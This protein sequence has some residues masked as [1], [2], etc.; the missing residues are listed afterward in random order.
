MKLAL[1]LPRTKL[2]ALKAPKY[3]LT[4]EQRDKLI[5]ALEAVPINERFAVIVLW[6]QINGVQRYA[7][8]VQQVFSSAKWQATVSAAGLAFGHGISFLFSQ[9]AY[10][11]KAKR[12]AE[13]VKLMGLFEQAG[14]HYTVGPLRNILVP[15]V[16]M[17]GAE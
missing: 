4:Y 2:T 17:V 15:Y 12:P 9:E 11:D 10:D 1:R 16:F 14:V 7:D 6:P 8:D 3:P 5:K 13:A